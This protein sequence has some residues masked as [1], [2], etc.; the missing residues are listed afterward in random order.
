[1]T[2]APSFKE[3]LA[4][5]CAFV[6]GLGPADNVAASSLFDYARQF[7]AIAR[8]PET[9]PAALSLRTVAAAMTRKMSSASAMIEPAR[10]RR[11]RIVDLTTALAAVIAAEIAEGKTAPPLHAG[12]V[13]SDFLTALQRASAEPPRAH[14]AAS[15][16]VAAAATHAVGVDPDADATL[17]HLVASLP[18]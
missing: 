4:R 18:Q 13:L 16:L 2:A 8:Q 15:M 14:V 7:A 3:T 5:F 17:R 6:D 11:M 1:M 9:A 12:P 10:A